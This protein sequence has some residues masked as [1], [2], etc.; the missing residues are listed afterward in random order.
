MLARH[1]FRSF[2]FPNARREEVDRLRV[3]VVFCVRGLGR[4]TLS[5][6]R[7]RGM[8]LMVEISDI[9]AQRLDWHVVS[10]VEVVGILSECVVS[11]YY[12]PSGREKSAVPASRVWAI[13]CWLG[14]TV[15]ET[16]WSE[17]SRLFSYFVQI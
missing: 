2:G 8:L 6:S 9:R 16:V 1:T 12:T 3:A 7:L 15:Y 10:W 14:D 4:D 5:L 11:P 17:R 13:W